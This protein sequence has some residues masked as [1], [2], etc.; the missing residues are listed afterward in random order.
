MNKYVVLL[1]FH[2]W[3]KGLHLRNV[4]LVLYTLHS[5]CYLLCVLLYNYCI[6]L[7]CVHKLPVFFCR[8]DMCD[9]LYYVFLH[10]F[11]VCVQILDIL[12]T[13]HRLVICV[14]RCVY[15]NSCYYHSSSHCFLY[16]FLSDKGNN[17]RGVSFVLSVFFC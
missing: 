1:I 16:L 12:D 11:D 13:D 4:V 10:K 7:Q 2:S 8:Y 3:S 6:L 5:L 9:L 15:R 17:C 14:H